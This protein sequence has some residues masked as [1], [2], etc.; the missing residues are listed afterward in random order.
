[1]RC[2][3]KKAIEITITYAAHAPVAQLDRA[4]DY[5]SEGYGFDFCRA[6]HS[7][8][9]GLQGS[10][11]FLCENSRVSIFVMVM[12]RRF[13]TTCSQENKCFMKPELF[14]YLRGYNRRACA[15]DIVAGIIVGIIAIPLSVALAI[16]SGASPEAGLYTAII[17]GFAAA[18]LGGSSVQITGPTGAFVVIV[19]GI[20]AKYGISGLIT[21]TLMAGIMLLL[22]GVLKFGSVIK[23]VPY[24]VTVGFTAGIAVT[25]FFGQIN[26][27]SG[28]RLESVPAEFLEKLHLYVENINKIDFISLA[29]G[30]ISVVIILLW[31]KINKKIPGS[32]IAIIV[33][34]IA[35]RVLKLPVETIGSRFNDLSGGFP[36]F[37]FPEINLPLIQKLLQPAFTI[38]VL[39]GIESLLSAVVADE[40]T[41]TRHNANQELIGQGVAN[42][43]SSLFGGLPATGAIAR[44]AA[45]IRNGGISPVSAIVHSLTVLLV[46]VLFLPLAK[47]IPMPVLAGILVVVCKNMIEIEAI[48]GLLRAPWSDRLLLIATFILTV[49]FDLVVAI[50]VGLLMAAILFMKR[51]ADVAEINERSFTGERKLDGIGVYRLNGPF[52]FAAAHSLMHEIEEAAIEKNALILEMQRVPALDGGAI[53]A[54]EKLAAHC[55]KHKTRLFLV[56][57]QTQPAAALKQSAFCAGVGQECIMNDIESAFAACD[58]LSD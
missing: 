11:V 44:T 28:M 35:A 46:T 37:A 47:Q 24:P 36:P 4:S 17:A 40:M 51:M 9:P 42:I 50:Q 55:A 20:I 7:R 22:M 13:H 52:F 5:G 1:M 48:R 58:S 3:T 27:L 14:L 26:D 54:L 43:A 53:H 2:L 56:R 38:A 31:P 33:M 57:L 19:Y 30:L 45:N 15:K 16:A 6:R 12:V 29:T 25:I 8:D 18:V 32:L 34:T 21:A 41:G 49:V 10:G 23:Y 39:G